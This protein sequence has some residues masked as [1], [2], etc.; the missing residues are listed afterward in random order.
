M[1]RMQ[2]PLNLPADRADRIAR[3]LELEDGCVLA[4][5]LPAK[6]GFLPQNARA[7]G[8]EAPGTGVVALA[9]FVQLA[10]R[11]RGQTLAAF[12]S[13]L[14]LDLQ[15]VVE[16]ESGCNA[17]ELRVLHTLATGLGVSYTKLQVLVGYRQARDVSLQREAL[18]FAASSGPM[19]KLSKVEEQALH[20]FVQ[21]LHD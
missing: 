21:A 18:K 10:R 8:S 3:A 7:A 11:E 2:K 15:E 4:G 19:D 14:G 9:R 5:G 13:K 6:L 12:A 16:L 20:D 1:S 17:P